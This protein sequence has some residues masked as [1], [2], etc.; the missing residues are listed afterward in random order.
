MTWCRLIV[1][2]IAAAGVTGVAV[3]HRFEPVAGVGLVTMVIALAVLAD[4]D[5]RTQRL[6]N[7][8]VGPLA[9]GVTVA[10]IVGGVVIDDMARA[11]IAIVVGLV[12]AAALLIANIAGGM[13]MGDVKL[14]FPIGVVAGWLGT[15]AVLATGF[16][17]S[18]TGGPR[19]R[20]RHGAGQEPIA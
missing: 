5:L 1:A 3:T 16:V 7:H 20:C 9:F 4:I 11:G 13:G 10:A 19:R 15:N 18:L 6:P 8:I 17:G 14:S 2:V 12:F